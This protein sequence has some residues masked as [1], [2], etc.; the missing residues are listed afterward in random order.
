MSRSVTHTTEQIS[1]WFLD[2]GFH[3]TYR[4]TAIRLLAHPDLPGVEARI[5]TGYVVVDRDGQEIFR[6][7][8]REFESDDLIARVFP[9]T[10]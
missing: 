10:S 6:E 4:S 3:L 5:G 9:M 7:L 8:I 2:Q 1:N